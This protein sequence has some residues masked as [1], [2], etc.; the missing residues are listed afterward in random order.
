M[1]GQ[2]LPL[3]EQG[4]EHEDNL[5]VHVKGCGQM[6]IDIVILS[7]PFNVYIRRLSKSNQYSTGY[8]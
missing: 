1:M 2:M 7:V 5:G 4:I 8:A 6:T 3:R